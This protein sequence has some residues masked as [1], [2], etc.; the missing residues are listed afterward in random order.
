[1]PTASWRGPSGDA[2]PARV[3]FETR[4]RR[5]LL[6][7]SDVDATFAKVVVARRRTERV[8]HVVDT[9]ELVRRLA[10]DRSG[11]V[12]FHVERDGATFAGAAPEWLVRLG[13]DL[14][15][16]TEAVAGTRPVADRG[17]LSGSA[18]DRVEH[19]LVVRG[20]VEALG[21]VATAIERRGPSVREHGASAHLA[22]EIRAVANPGVRVLDLVHALH[23]T[24]A[25]SGFPRGTSA[26][27]L[28]ENEALGRGLYAGPVGVFD[29]DG[30][31]EF[32][33]ALRSFLT[34]GTE[35]SFFAGAGIVRG[36][37]PSEE[38]DETTL[39]MRT[40]TALFDH[41]PP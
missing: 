9:A 6:A 27:W 17:E 11:G 21:P 14:R 25:T 16:A 40:A 10:N 41:G 8:D 29:G 5:A 4:V 33:V 20:I 23:P 34:R 30:R 3:D 28:R 35:V 26:A 18:K 15:V 36:S 22:T 19:G 7:M 13:A 12:I 37:S 1:M 31:G 2:P 32:A 24:A 39:K 38:F